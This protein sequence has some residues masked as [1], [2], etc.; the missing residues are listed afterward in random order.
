MRVATLNFWGRSGAWPDRRIVDCRLVFEK[1]AAS[2]HY[3]LVAEL[4]PFDR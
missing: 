1:P 2:D 3:G 4:E